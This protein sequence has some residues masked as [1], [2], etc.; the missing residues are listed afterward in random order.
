MNYALKISQLKMSA[1]ITIL[2]GRIIVGADGKYNHVNIAFNSVRDRN[3]A[4]TLLSRQ[5]WSCTDYRDVAGSAIQASYTG[6][7]KPNFLM[8]P[9]WP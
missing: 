1:I 8:L 9:L 6:I 5:G 7:K 3:I 2:G 4:L